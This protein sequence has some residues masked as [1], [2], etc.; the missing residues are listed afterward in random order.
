MKVSKTPFCCPKFQCARDRISPKIID[1]FGTRS[2]KV[3]PALAYCTLLFISL[4]T[5]VIILLSLFGW[6]LVFMP[7]EGLAVEGVCSSFRLLRLLKSTHM[8]VCP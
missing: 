8:S 2:Q 1:N 7:C 4:N 6:S 5:V 3:S